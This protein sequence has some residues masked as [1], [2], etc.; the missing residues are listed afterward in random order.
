MLDGVFR[1]F[2][3]SVVVLKMQYWRLP[4]W[5]DRAGHSSY[6]VIIV[7]VPERYNKVLFHCW[8][9]RLTSGTAGLGARTPHRSVHNCRQN[10]DYRR[11]PGEERLQHRD[12]MRDLGAKTGHFWPDLE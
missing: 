10:C 7:E 11:H 8:H 5:S 3:W 4:T 2:G 1:L 9:R 12:Y 6:D